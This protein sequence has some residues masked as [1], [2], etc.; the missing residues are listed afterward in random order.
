MAVL[1]AA[2][3]A[4]EASAIIELAGESGWDEHAE[5]DVVGA[6]P[7]RIGADGT[8]L[9]D[10]FLPLE[11][12]A[13]YG[14]SAASAT[15]LVRDVVN[16]HARHP[17]LWA[18]VQDGRIPLW[19]AR[20]IT[21]HAASLELNADETAVVDERIAP[22][23]GRV[24]WRRLWWLYRAA[25]LALAPERV[26]ALTER[27]RADRFVRTGVVTDDPTVSYLTGRVDTAA[28]IGFDALL[29]DIADA[30]AARGD[31]DNRAHLRARALGLLAEPAEIVELL[32]GRSPE[33]KPSTRRPRTRV[34]VHLS[35]DDLG[36]AGVARVE[37][38]GPVLADELR[39]LV[40][41][42]TVQLTP[43]L[44]LGDA[45]RA[46]DA[47][48]VPDRVRAEVVLRDRY[49]VFPSSA[50]EGRSGDLDH[51]DPYQPGRRRQTRS[52]N[53]GPLGRPAHRAKTHG[54]WQLAQPRPGVFWWT[55]PRGQV[56]RVGP[57]GTRNLTPGDPARASSATERLMLWEVDRL[58]GGSRGDVA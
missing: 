6:R 29:D 39:H 49:E 18:A 26:S 57:D 14:I 5:F 31:T 53:L 17:H 32:A 28:A 38:L 52:S 2:L 58:L 48:E 27:S 24:Q 36:P 44:R 41:A 21:C 11:V 3:D 46:V 30:L 35:A 56:Y 19:R 55:S 13:A 42:G 10:E 34:Y 50:L 47:Y 8:R 4:A 45:E 15:W 54:G 16:L 51:T 7:I 22:A 9:V 12:A 23:V 1:R 33:A 25:V 43:V 37:G 20:Q 40:G